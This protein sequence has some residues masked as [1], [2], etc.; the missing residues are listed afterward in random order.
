MNNI[1][2]IKVSNDSFVV[3]LEK[4]SLKFNC[5]DLNDKY[6]IDISDMNLINATKTAI[7]CSTFCFIKNIQKKLCW[8]V[9]DEEIKRA[10]SILRL[11]NV[12]QIVK[13]KTEEKRVI[14]AS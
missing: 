3:E 9:K 4:S 6:I 5:K 13:E 1:R 8:L 14:L 12:E 2:N 10:I 7:F 11:R